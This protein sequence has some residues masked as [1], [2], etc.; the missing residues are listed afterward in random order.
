MK[1]QQP[2]YWQPW[3]A[4]SCGKHYRTI[5]DEETKQRLR[6]RKKQSKKKRS[7][8]ATKFRSPITVVRST[9]CNPQNSQWPKKQR[10]P[11]QTY[12]SNGAKLIGRISAYTI[13]PIS[14][15]LTTWGCLCQEINCFWRVYGDVQWVALDDLKSKET[16]RSGPTYIFLISWWWLAHDQ[17]TRRVELN[18]LRFDDSLSFT[19]KTS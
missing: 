6:M 17:E 4:H 1:S 18:C 8:Y 11:D 12:L 19:W 5:E 10:N 15:Q 7:T 13:Y 16:R 9:L 14:H 3:H 2:T